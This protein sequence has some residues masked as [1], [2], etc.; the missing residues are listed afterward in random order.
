MSTTPV[1]DTG[2]ARP[3]AV[4]TGA[5]RGIGA[6]V[7]RQLGQA[8]YAVLV[9]ARDLDAAEG[10]A[11]TLVADGLEAEP[12]RLDIGDPASVADLAASLGPRPVAV[13]VNN[14]AAFAD[15]SET[16]SGADLDNARQ[17]MDTNLFGPWRVT[18]ALLPALE[19]SVATRGSA[20]VVNVGS[21]SGS[22]GDPQFGLSSHPASVSYAVSKAALH[23][24]TVKMASELRDRGVRVDAVDP[25]LTATAPG[26]AEMGARPVADGARSVVTA[27]LL[28]ADSPTGTFTRDG[29][30]LAW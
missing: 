21:G 12:A 16:A 25:G 13:L 9:T 27:A 20:Q 1:Q 28:A 2:A 3:L 11:A 22:H 26:M 19:R 4:V 10:H 15:W 30:P 23:A 14:A 24:L 17:V 5:A 6:D 29:T 7:A 8:G 18:Q